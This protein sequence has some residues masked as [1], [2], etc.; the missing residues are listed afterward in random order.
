MPI[1]QTRNVVVSLE[2][3]LVKNSLYQSDIDVLVLNPPNTLKKTWV[4]SSV[5]YTISKIFSN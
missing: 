5:P 2:H 4:P 1:C 3:K